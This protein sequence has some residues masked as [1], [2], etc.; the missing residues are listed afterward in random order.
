LDRRSPEELDAVLVDHR[1]G[2]RQAMDYLLNLGHTRIGF[3]S[4]QD[5]DFPV[6]D[7]LRGYHEALD[8]RGMS[9]DDRLVRTGSFGIDYAYSEAVQFFSLADPPTAIIAGGT[10]LLAGVLR[11]VR[12]AGRRIPEDVSVIGGQESELAQLHSPAISVIRWDHGQLGIAAARFLINRLQSV[13]VGVQ[14][15]I[16]PSE[17]IIRGSCGPRGKAA[18][19]RVVAAAHGKVAKAGS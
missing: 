8:A 2:I 10:T 14:R 5:T 13:A 17:L 9:C 19:I 7:R 16:F 11:A 3:I 12:E 4:G 1:A 18:R 6:R 15:M